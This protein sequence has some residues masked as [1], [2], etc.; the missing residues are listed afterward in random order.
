MQDYGVSASD[1]PQVYLVNVGDLAEQ[2]AFKIAELLRNAE[3]EVVLHAGGGSFKSQMKK[4]DRSQAQFALIL[5]D[6]E[7][8]Q[9]QVILK[10]MQAS[11]EQLLCSIDE[12]IKH[13]VTHRSL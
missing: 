5:G 4:A 1:A 8:A 3:I 10:P 2:Q 6:D 11:G 12:A 9:Q 13:L 7:V